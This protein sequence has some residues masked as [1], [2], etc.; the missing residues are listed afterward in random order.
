MTCDCNEVPQNLSYNCSNRWGKGCS[1]N[2]GFNFVNLWNYT[3]N[4]QQS[5]SSDS[6]LFGVNRISATAQ[7]AA[8]TQSSCKAIAGPGWAY[9]PGADIWTRLT[10]WKFPLLQ[11]VSS[12]PR[13]PLGFWVQMFVINHLL[14]DPID[15]MKNLF[16][17][18][19][20]CQQ[21]AEYWKE[22]CQPQVTFDDDADN[23][24]WKALTIIEDTY[25]E[26]GI[27]GEVRKTL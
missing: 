5:C 10:T 9:Y 13:P 17:K 4:I 1:S 23:R 25:A 8:L 2:A 22:H 16:T 3:R 19:S 27:E 15:T 26:C 24:D 20:N 21:T 14:G 7:N 18:M 6:R 12:F 11:L